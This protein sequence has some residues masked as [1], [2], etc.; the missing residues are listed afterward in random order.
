MA[1]CDMQRLQE[2]MSIH[3]I[4]HRKIILPLSFALGITSFYKFN[5][6]TNAYEKH[7][8][9]NVQ[10]NKVGALINISDIILTESIVKKFAEAVAK[11]KQ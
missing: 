10:M 4:E 3:E 9:C 5:H 1:L 8:K 6:S 11:L 2:S 7:N